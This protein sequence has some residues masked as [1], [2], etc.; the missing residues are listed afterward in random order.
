MNQRKAEATPIKIVGA[1]KRRDRSPNFSI[2]F[3]RNQRSIFAA[4]TTRQIV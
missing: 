3:R 2:L 4:S 1:K